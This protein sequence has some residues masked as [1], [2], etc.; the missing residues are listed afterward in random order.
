VGRDNPQRIDMVA[1]GRQLAGTGW[2]RA[3]ANFDVTWRHG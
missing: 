3:D 2:L 1:S